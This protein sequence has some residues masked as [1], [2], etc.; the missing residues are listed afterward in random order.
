MR[1]AKSIIEFVIVMFEYEMT[2]VE[3]LLLRKIVKANRAAFVKAIKDG[4]IPSRNN[5]IQDIIA[6]VDKQGTA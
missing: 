6:Y 3:D 4:E 2:E 5:I 1:D